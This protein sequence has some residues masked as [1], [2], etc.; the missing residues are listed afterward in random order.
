MQHRELYTSRGSSDYDEAV[1]AT[2]GGRRELIADTALALIAERGLRG[3]THRAVDAAAGLPPGS[4]SYYART[5][6]ALLAAAVNRMAD[7]ELATLGPPL[8]PGEPQGVDRLATVIG[9]MLVTAA[10]TGR[11]RTL[12]RYELALEAA[13]SPALSGAYHAAGDRFRASASAA[14]AALGSPDPDRHGRMLVSWC[15]GVIFECA[16]G[17]PAA[18]PPTPDELAAGVRDLVRGVLAAGGGGS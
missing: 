8:Q 2:P 11:D 14:M 5:R 9:Q 16:I 13:R 10:T 1:I 15:E 12:A 3:L 18:S 4:T 7:L 17:T 6:A